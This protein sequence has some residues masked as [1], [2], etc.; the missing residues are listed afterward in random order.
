M[1]ASFEETEAKPP[2][3]H[4]IC[5]ILEWRPKQSGEPVTLP[6]ASKQQE[7]VPAVSF[8]VGQ[9]RGPVG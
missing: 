2:V 5:Q 8:W 1:W 7:S 6:R 3:G 4:C 9:A